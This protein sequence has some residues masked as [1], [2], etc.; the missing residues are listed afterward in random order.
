MKEYFASCFVKVESAAIVEHSLFVVLV[1][2][3]LCW[4]TCG[5]I[6]VKPCPG[7]ILRVKVNYSV[8]SSQYDSYIVIMDT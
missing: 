1:D 8:I 5:R 6:V 4:R 7:S 3:E 2:V